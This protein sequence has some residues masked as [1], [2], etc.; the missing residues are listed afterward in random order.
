M[1]HD[2]KGPQVT[3]KKIFVKQLNQC[4]NHLA[5]YL[6]QVCLILAM[7]NQ[8]MLFIFANVHYTHIYY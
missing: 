1:M 3:G 7:L 8:N 2:V 4:N 6:L 5:V